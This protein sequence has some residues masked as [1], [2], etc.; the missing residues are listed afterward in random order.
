MEAHLVRDGRS[1]RNHACGPISRLALLLQALWRDGEVM[2]E[3]L[4]SKN[5]ISDERLHRLRADW[6]QAD[7]TGCY[8][9][10]IEASDVL[11]VCDELIASR[12]AHEPRALKSLTEPTIDEIVVLLNRYAHTHLVDCQCD[13]AGDCDY[14]RVEALLTFIREQSSQLPTECAGCEEFVKMQHDIASILGV[15]DDTDSISLHDRIYGALSVRAAQP[16]APE[17]Q[18][19]ETA[20]RDAEDIQLC[21]LYSD[22]SSCQA[23]GYWSES[24]K[25]WVICSLHGGGPTHWRPLSSRPTKGSAP[26][27]PSGG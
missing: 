7:E 19:I 10:V 24:A 26:C 5:L 1:W 11:L 15:D 20:P 21:R 2:S 23:I 9:G 14:C 6:A 25:E 3:Q 16:P 17:W 4:P 18:P 13:D 12:A 8:P 27:D 22:G